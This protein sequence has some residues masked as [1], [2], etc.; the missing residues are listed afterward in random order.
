MPL[1]TPVFISDLVITNPPST[2]PKSEGAAHLRNIKTAIKSTFPNVTG[3]VTATQLELNQLAGSTS[4]IQAQLNTKAPSASPV[5]T[6]AATLPAA[7]TIGTV[8]AAEVL[9]L[10]GVTSPVQTQLNTKAPLLSPV[11]TGVVN[12]P[13]TGFGVSEAVTKSYA[14]AL[15][16]AAALPAQTGNAGKIITTNGVSASWQTNRADLPITIVTATTQT[17][18]DGNHYVMSNAALSTLTLP[19]TPANGAGVEITFANGRTDNVVA[20]NGSGLLVTDAGV[21]IL[22][23]MVYDVPSVSLSLV[24]AG[25]AWRFEAQG[26]SIAIT[27]TIETTA[28]NLRNAT[29]TA[30]LVVRNNTEAAA[31]LARGYEVPIAYTTGINLTRTTQTVSQLGV[32]YAPAPGTLPF[33]T[34]GTFETAKFRVITGGVLGS[35]LAAST[36]ASLV[37]FTNSRGVVSTVAGLSIKQNMRNNPSTSLDGEAAGLRVGVCQGDEPGWLLNPAAGDFVAIAPYISTANGRSRAWA[38]N[39]I[40]D[41]PAGSP[42]T[43]WCIEGNVNV[44]TANAPN[45]RLPNHALGVDMVSGGPFAPSA[46]FLTS[47]TTLA[48][49]WKYGLWFDGVGG[50]PGSALIKSNVNVSVDFGIDLGS[51]VI[52]NQALRIGATPLTLVC[53]AGVRQIT[54]AA[55]GIFLQRNTDTAPTGNMLQVVDA[56]NTVVLASIDVLGNI[57]GSSFNGPLVTNGT[58]PLAIGDAAGDIQWR[59]PLVALGGGVAPTFGTIGGLGPTAAVQFGWQRFIDSTGAVF[60]LPAWK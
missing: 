57:K 1:E 54:N 17:A 47:S 30:A 15:S 11:F 35:D 38:F 7:T 52:N 4:A 18:V 12:L 51:A 5:F 25:N 53:A 58:S 28:L 40:V 10:S 48:N 2:D 3:A 26:S 33:T 14:D 34:S 49:R 41:A 19:A 9:R 6:V 45:P 60:W 32:V 27:E 59:R 8:T 16:M 29:E 36:G 44:A 23:D 31:L 20:R 24:Y 13:P 22:E 37:G 55:I 46:A 42:G 43:I 39:P 50:Q 56:G 21:P